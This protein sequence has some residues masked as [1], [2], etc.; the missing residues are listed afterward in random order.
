MNIVVHVI[1]KV[2]YFIGRLMGYV[3]GFIDGVKMRLFGGN[4]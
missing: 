4:E 1:Q 3:R 2:C